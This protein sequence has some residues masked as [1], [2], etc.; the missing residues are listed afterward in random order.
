MSLVKVVELAAGALLMKNKPVRFEQDA[1]AKPL[2][3]VIVLGIMT[4]VKLVQNLKALVPMLATPL[5][6]VRLV[7]LVQ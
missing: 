5:E 7:R 6:I 1:K 2:R 3:L 4:L